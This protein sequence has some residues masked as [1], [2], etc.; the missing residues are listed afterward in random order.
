MDSKVVSPVPYQTILQLDL[1]ESFGF[2]TRADGES[3]V[4]GLPELQ[5]GQVLGLG[6]LRVWIW[7]A[8][9]LPPG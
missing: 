5:N 3:G 9:G 4:L 1:G 8:L 2:L 7:V 6:L